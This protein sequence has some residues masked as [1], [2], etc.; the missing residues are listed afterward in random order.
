MDKT[1]LVFFKRWKAVS[2]ILG[3]GAVGLA[4]MVFLF[5]HSSHRNTQLLAQ[6]A[7]KQAESDFN[8]IK[9]NT[10]TML[11][12]TL[13]SL[14][15]NK[16]IIHSFQTKNREDLLK[17]VSHFFYH[18]RKK[19]RITH[20]YFINPPPDSTCF[21]RVHQPKKNGDEITRITYADAVKR[22]ELSVG[23]ELGKTAF[24]LRAVHP[25]YV[26]GQ[27]IGFMELAV[28]MD[29]F[30][31]SLKRQTGN[32]Y[33][34][35]VH[36]K[37]L[38]KKKWNSVTRVKR[39]KNNWDDKKDLLLIS[40]TAHN[41]NLIQ[42]HKNITDIP[43]GGLVLE[44]I[45]TNDKVFVRGLFPLYDAASRKVGGI[46]VL[47]DVTGIL[48]SMEQQKR[49]V[50]LMVI[51]FMAVL[52]FFMI[53]F[54]SRAQRQLQK[55]REKLEKSL[56]VRTDELKIQCNARVE[57]EKHQSRAIRQA[58]RARRLASIGV[59]AAGI[60]H[61]INQP[62]NA[63]KVTTDSILFWNRRNPGAVPE[64][65][66]DQLGN[67]SK[68]V[69]RIT[70][71]I[72]H[73]RMFWVVPDAPDVSLIDLNQAV[74]HAMDLIHNQLDSHKTHY[75]LQ[76]SSSPVMFK[77]NLIHIEQIVI[78]LAINADN[79]L[80]ELPAD[81]KKEKNILIRTF[82][83]GKSAVF[84]ISDNGPGIPEEYLDKLFDPFFSSDASSIET[85]EGMGLGLAIVQSYIDRYGGSIIVSNNPAGGATFTVRFPV[86]GN[87]E[88]SNPMDSD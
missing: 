60:T 75:R 8:E 41:E 47:K 65:L 24:A 38:D 42:Y 25:F 33:G 36:K 22:D 31:Q 50:M 77:S 2:F 13:E 79:A 29:Y 85:A 84:E 81:S 18:I 40:N 46:F 54:H 28:D 30:F 67:I 5:N 88:K 51:L 68:S 87:R 6:Y 80:K 59:M 45:K 64:V 86:V 12:T 16:E 32:E 19:S 61:E 63:I 26:E 56:E 69:N 73:I 55:Y 9:R 71:I 15:I 7:V 35:L 20:W 52:I 39:I 74:R 44:K 76:L 66:L 57:A 49:N 37:Y 1:V 14:L 43:D 17:K 10:V 4:G 82:I 48:R 78:N 53:F 21:L 72:R 58:A 70:E 83:D 62:L 23:I 34:L 27:L 3:L 11:T